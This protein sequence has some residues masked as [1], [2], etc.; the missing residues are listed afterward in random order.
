MSCIL[1]CFKKGIFFILA[2]IKRV[3]LQIPDKNG[4]LS[5]MRIIWIYLEY[6]DRF[7]PKNNTKFLIQ[8]L[9]LIKRNL[10]KLIFMNLMFKIKNYSNIE[11]TEKN[12]NSYIELIYKLS[13]LNLSSKQK[14]KFVTNAIE[15]LLYDAFYGRG[16]NS[17]DLAFKNIEKISEILELENSKTTQNYILDCARYIF[18]I[19]NTL[20]SLEVV[21]DRLNT[22]QLLAMERVSLMLGFI[23]SSYL[24]KEKAREKN[25]QIF[26]AQDDKS[27]NTIK[28]A[29]FSALEIGD[30]NTLKDVLE[31]AKRTIKNQKFVDTLDYLYQLFTKQNYRKAFS[32]LS[33][34]YEL[35]FSEFIKN[36]S[37]AIVAP[38]PVKTL[39][40]SL[41]D[42][43]DYILRMSTTSHPSYLDSQIY[44][45]RTDIASINIADIQG[46]KIMKNGK[47]DISND[48]KYLIFK[49][50]DT[51]IL[52]NYKFHIPT[53]RKR[54]LYGRVYTLSGFLTHIPELVLFLLGSGVSKIS[55]FSMNFFM[56]S[57]SYDKNYRS[58]PTAHTLY[59]MGDNLA[60]SHIYLKK[61]YDLGLIECDE[62]A[63]EVISLSTKEYLENMENI[64]RDTIKKYN[65]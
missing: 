54:T 58:L 45:S 53:I 17:K 37:V 7:M 57:S 11:I 48:L 39:S 1:N 43:H 25:I 23:S 18:N 46:S 47:S 27:A 3:V 32:K 6:I 15:I 60:S 28:N 49:N 20:P 52:K 33:N 35:E 2:K 44:G 40:G 63:L 59:F 12:W 5:K 16:V 21:D 10:L 30:M 62:S 4:G 8:K 56:A 19:S 9:S 24:F 61:L 22:F 13:S 31:V 41:I 29:F 36:K 26:Y 38:L 50:L 51:T 14:T 55:L 42:S 34:E 64:Y 65:R